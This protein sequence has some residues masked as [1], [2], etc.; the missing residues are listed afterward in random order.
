MYSMLSFY[1]PIYWH[2]YYTY[3]LVL[4]VYK[5]YNGHIDMLWPPAAS[6][7]PAPPTPPPTTTKNTTQHSMSL[8]KN[9]HTHNKTETK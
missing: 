2:L 6:G 3:F 9:K 8:H 5:K 7:I 4:I 1:Y